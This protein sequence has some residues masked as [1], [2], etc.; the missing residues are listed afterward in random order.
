MGASQAR[1][2][3]GESAPWETGAPP[4][5]RVERGLGSLPELVWH[6]T[7]I[8]V[9]DLW[10]SAAEAR[11]PDAKDIPVRF[12]P[13]LRAVRVHAGGG[14]ARLPFDDLQRAAEFL[15]PPLRS[16]LARPSTRLARAHEPV[17]WERLDELD[18]RSLAWLSRLP[19]RTTREKSASTQ[20]ALGVVRVHTPDVAENRVLVR[21][22]RDLRPWLERRLEMTRDAAAAPR[23]RARHDLMQD[24]ARLLRDEL[25]RALPAIGPAQRPEPNNALLGSGHY[26]KV[27]RAWR[28]LVHR[29]QRFAGL[30][31]LGPLLLRGGL[32]LLV[33]ERLA[34]R[35]DAFV[36]EDL[37]T[38]RLAGDDARFG[39]APAVIDVLLLSAHPRC[40]SI[41]TPAGGEPLRVVIRDPAQARVLSTLEVEASFAPESIE[42]GRGCPVRVAWIDADR[43]VLDEA[44]GWFDADGVAALVDPLVAAL[45]LEAEAAMPRLFVAGCRAGGGLDPRSQLVTIDLAPAVPLIADESGA[46]ASGA[47]CVAID[48]PRDAA[49]TERVVGDDALA[50]Q[51][52]RDPRSRF[53][54]AASWDLIAA[55]DC[56]VADLAAALGPLVA[57]DSHPDRELCIPV[58]DALGEPGEALLRAALPSHVRRAWLVPRA[59]TAA[60]ALR[61]SAS[62]AIAVDEPLVILDGGPLGFE[63]RLAVLRVAST[64]RGPDPWFWEC[65]LPWPPRPEAKPGATRAFWRELTREAV[66]PDAVP[67][68]IDL[69]VDSGVAARVA[70]DPHGRPG[71]AL[72]GPGALGPPICFTRPAIEAAAERYARWFRDWLDALPDALSEAR[73]L[74]GRQRLNVLVVGELLALPAVAATLRAQCRAV[75]PEA[76][77]HVQPIDAPFARGGVEF[78]RRTRAGSLTFELALPDLYLKSIGAAGVAASRPIFQNRRVQPGQEVS[79]APMPFEIPAGVPRIELPLEREPGGRRPLAFRAVLDGEGLPLRAPMRVD[80]H[81]T[82]RYADDGF[83]IRIRPRQIDDRSASFGE[84]EVRWVRAEAPASAGPVCNDPPGFPPPRERLPAVAGPILE[85]LATFRRA[86]DAFLEDHIRGRRGDEGPLAR[87]LEQ[88]AREVAA[89]T[90]G[91]PSHPL[92]DRALVALTDAWVTPLGLL[93]DLPIDPYRK[94]RTPGWTAK[95]G[96]LRK[97]LPRL[98]AAAV[99]GLSRL[100]GSAPRGLP[101]WLLDEA[102]RRARDGKS[103]DD[104]KWKCLGRTI[105]ALPDP[106]RGRAAIR[107]VELLCQPDRDAFGAWWALATALWSEESLVLALP[108]ESVRRLLARIERAVATAAAPR[109]DLFHEVGTVLLALLRRRGRPEAG[110]VDAGTPLLRRLADRFEDIDRGFVA[111]G[112]RREPRLKI[113]GQNDPRADVSGFVDSLAAALRGERVALIRMLED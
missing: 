83:R 72:D 41:Q 8:F 113:A 11:E 24:L 47:C 101:R 7:M 6:R 46:I 23:D 16:I 77:L 35:A 52:G 66:G 14:Y 102:E 43:G 26:G 87:Q 71:A 29:G 110:P 95:A 12:R 50:M 106:D 34:R 79:V 100:G 69:L 74:A 99:V 56:P 94:H 3:R 17:R 88:H 90:A 81:I 38:L 59:I 57:A 32:G 86:C 9:E 27:W 40:V 85:T 28:W 37:A 63:G 70:T 112:H 51:V 84:R 4:L 1:T 104:E 76:V 19:G 97:Q 68:Y 65:P 31:S 15:G 93:A 48:F 44:C 5:D 73:A 75:L 36:V 80:L 109:L 20:R 45:E 60:M 105:H 82:Y 22:A 67:A 55:G 78:L 42:P 30:W 25:P 107:V 64:H 53:S 91:G 61:A 92:E 49:R 58:P 21:L 111:S 54:L 89:L 108:E 18:A 62:D 98:R 103:L 10:A 2:E 33:A 96:E 39:I 13:L